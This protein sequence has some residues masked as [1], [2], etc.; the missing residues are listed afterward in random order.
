VAKARQVQH[1]PER[2]KAKGRELVEAKKEIK[3][4]KRQVS[5]LQK[6]VRKMEESRGV[7]IQLEE[8]SPEPTLAQGTAQPVELANEPKCSNCGSGA[9]VSFRPPNSSRTLIVCKDC[10]HK[11]R[12]VDSL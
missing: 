8:E 4:L 11:T 7:E 6:T 10:K 5:R 3:Q 9:L 1:K 2:E 12:N